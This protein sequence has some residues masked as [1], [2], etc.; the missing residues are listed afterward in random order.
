MK[1]KELIG[2]GILAI[3]IGFTFFAWDR[4]EEIRSL[5]VRLAALED[6]AYT[7]YPRIT[8]EGRAAVYAGESKVIVERLEE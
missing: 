8:I 2:Y 1:T 7:N 6:A 5:N 4:H 3:A